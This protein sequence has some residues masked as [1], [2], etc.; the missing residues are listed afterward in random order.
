MSSQTSKEIVLRACHH[1]S[2]RNLSALF[3]LVHEEGSWSIPY[4]ADRFQFA[5]F[6]NKQA[7]VDLLTG[8]LGAFERFSFEAITATAEEDRLV[9]EYKCAAQAKNGTYDQSYITLMRFKGGKL[10]LF[11]E[12][13]DTTEVTRACGNLGESS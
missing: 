1:L 13:W 12:Y 7:F 6:R 2:E 5:G 8:F 10:C 4:R 11:R 9:L 3:D